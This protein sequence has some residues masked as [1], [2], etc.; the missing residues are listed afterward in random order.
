MPGGT[1][2]PMFGLAVPVATRRLD[3]FP[4]FKVAVF[5]PARR[6]VPFSVR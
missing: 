6:K 1:A 3:F 4:R 2:Q 5:A